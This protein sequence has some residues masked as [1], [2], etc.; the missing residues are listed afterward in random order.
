[1]KNNS[2][3]PP[4]AFLKLFRWYCHPKLVDHIEGDLIEVYRQ[5]LE[6][7]GKNK[8]DIKFII[9]VLL[10][11]RPRIIKPMEGHQKVN[12]YG[13]YK[14]Y[15]KIGWRN[16][17]RNKG[18]S[19]INIG[20]LAIGLASGIFVIHYAR[21]E[22]SYDRFHNGADRIYRISTSRVKDGVE[23]RKYAST[24]AGV[25][26]A[27]Q[28]EFPEI[29]NYT[30]IFHRSRGGIITHNQVR[31]REEGIY[32]ADSGFFKV[33]SFPVVAGNSNDL[34]APNVAFIEEATA[35]KYFGD[36][37]PFGK[38]IT[39]GSVNGLEE[40]EI[41]GVLKCPENSSIKFNFIF[42]YS[43]LGRL[44]GTDH[45][46]N[47]LWLDFHTFIKL[48]QGTDSRALESRFSEVIKKH[49]SPTQAHML[50]SLQSL[51]S[52]YLESER[53]F[54][55]G[56]TGDASIV[57]VLLILGIVIIVIVSLNAINL[58]TSQAL[59]R[60]KEVGVR[61]VLGSTRG[62][63]ILQFY[64][65]TVVTN[66]LAIVVCCILLSISLPFFNE[67]TGRHITFSHLAQNYLW[68]YFA[69]FFVFGTFVIGAYSAFQLS[70]FRPSEVLKGLFSPTGHGSFLREVF[71]GFQG[72]VSFSL[73]VAI[74]VIMAQVKHLTT[75][76]LG[77]TI[78][79]TLAVRTPDVVI[80]RDDYLSSLDTYRNELKKDSRITNVSSSAD[81][82]GAAVNWIGNARRLGTD[83]N[84]SIS[85]Y[86]SIIDDEFVETTEVRMVE[87]N[88]FSQGQSDH[89]V[90]LNMK[91]IQ[92]LGFKSAEES[93]GQ[94]IVTALDTCRIIGVIDNF[95][96]V[97]PREPI[98]ATLYHYRLEDP[99]VFLI[100]FNS[101]ELTN[102]VSLAEFEYRKLFPG[103]AF[104]YYFLDEFYDKQYDSERTLSKIITLFCLLAVFVSSL[105]LLGLMWYRL[106]RQGKELAIRKI[107]GSTN[108]G[109]FYQ[110]SRRLLL[111]T[112]LGCC[113]GAPIIWYLMSQWLQSFVEHTNLGFWEFM[114]ALI[115]SV[116]LSLITISS[117]TLKVIRVNPVKYLR[118]E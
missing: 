33:F 39:F 101:S 31:F 98:A 86:R 60:A 9:D 48:K 21:I 116:L 78:N 71:V 55:T 111:T 41:R 56:K 40:Y 19:I 64:V 6:K 117:H 95:H 8:A 11:F 68:Q 89:D 46:S 96:Q 118:Q 66:L 4:Q 12:A 47:W 35:K 28:E 54:E 65:E 45:L 18:Y 91:A 42:S 106:S 83:P 104:D 79:Q 14:S 16:L 22:N 50:L 112:L 3:H 108:I 51:T 57:R 75:Q 53:E 2:N 69:I 43:N 32:H 29:E 61:K 59:A 109:L 113:V 107:M 20:G 92:D 5:R 77:I 114:V 105:G 27:F 26:P 88:D 73:V 62:N 85:I 110:A 70:A 13:M 97:S 76:D 93:I 115:I 84:Q 74:L 36:E 15:F 99:A 23:I 81:S 1:L 34:F 25:G 103:S 7:L 38:R 87:G 10:L 30:R 67:L 17:L 90:L 102:V 82:P 44:F 72:L 24:F 49:R 63:L 52:L 94:K 80:N 58:S 37:N 100:R